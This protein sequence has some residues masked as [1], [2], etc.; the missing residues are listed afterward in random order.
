LLIFSATVLHVRGSYD[1]AFQ[2]CQQICERWGWYNRNCAI[3]P[4]AVEEKK[5]VGLEICEQLDWKV[6][7]WVAVAVGDGCMIAGIWKVFREMK[8]LGLIGRVPKM[9]GCPSRRRGP[10]DDRISRR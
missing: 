8:I 3:N 6:P 9:L 4:Y 7:D 5:T 10:G 2:L 1:Q